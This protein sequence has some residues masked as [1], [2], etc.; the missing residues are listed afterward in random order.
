MLCAR[1]WRGVWAGEPK[2]NVDTFKSND[3]TLKSTEG[4]FKST[5]GT[6]GKNP[7][8]FPKYRL[9]WR[10][11]QAI[12]SQRAVGTLHKDFRGLRPYRVL[13]N[14]SEVFSVENAAKIFV[15]RL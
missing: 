8:Y 15:R 4:T 14:T 2:S 6:F 9:C 1:E 5:L 13:R 7:R 12:V 10:E 11:E 3:A